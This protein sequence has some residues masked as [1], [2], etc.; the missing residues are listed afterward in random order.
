LIFG[1]DP[2]F[3]NADHEE[4]PKIDPSSAL[5]FGVDPFFINA[6]HEESPKIDPIAS[7]GVCLFVCLSGCLVA[8]GLFV[9]QMDVTFFHLFFND[10]LGDQLSQNVMDRSSPNY[11]DMYTYGRA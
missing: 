3:I 8:G 10:P 1:V 6:D 4:S 7:T 2:F 5:I 11:L 9:L